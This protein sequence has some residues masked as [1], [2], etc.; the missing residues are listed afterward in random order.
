MN[1]IS[2]S[3]IGIEAVHQNKLK[4]KFGGGAESDVRRNTAYLQNEVSEYDKYIAGFRN[5][6]KMRKSI[7]LNVRDWRNEL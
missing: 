1:E 5:V 7:Y 2:K 6:L 3:A 4:F